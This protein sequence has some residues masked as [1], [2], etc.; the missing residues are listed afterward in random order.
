VGGSGFQFADGGLRGDSPV[1]RAAFTL[2]RAPG[3]LQQSAA[4]IERLLPMA[5]ARFWGAEVGKLAA[6]RGGA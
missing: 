3:A 4:G 5:P 2:Q 6:A 1:R